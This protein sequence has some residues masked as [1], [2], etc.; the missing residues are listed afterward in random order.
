ML[1]EF[2]DEIVLTNLRV[3]Q[4]T[5]DIALRRSGSRVL[6]DVLERT[7]DVRVVTTS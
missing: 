5:A 6:V 7:G 1:P 4:E 2:V 3:G